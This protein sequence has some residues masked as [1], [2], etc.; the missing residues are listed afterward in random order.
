MSILR[1]LCD[2][3]ELTA[4]FLLAVEA[5]K[6]K[7]LSWVRTKVHLLHKAV[8]PDIKFVEE[9]PTDLTFLQRHFMSIV[10]AGCW[11]I[12]ALMAWGII[13]RTPLAAYIEAPQGS[14]SWVLVIAGGLVVPLFLGVSAYD[15]IAYLLRSAIR[16]L[17]WLEENTLSGAVGI[18]GFGLF[19]TQFLLRRVL[20]L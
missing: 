12:G 17:L 8:N 19:T 11:L 2:V 16:A 9:L 13:T 3:F 6:L 1:I 20:A 5:I 18:L 4:V 7:N 10:L 15:G 14:I